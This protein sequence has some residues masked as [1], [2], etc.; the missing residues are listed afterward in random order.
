MN[1]RFR[2]FCFWSLH[3]LWSVSVRRSYLSTCDPLRSHEGQKAPEYDDWWCPWAITS[4]SPK[5]L[6]RCVPLYVV[7]SII[8]LIPTEVA[9]NDIAPIA[10]LALYGTQSKT[11]GWCS[12]F[13]NVWFFFYLLISSAVVT[14]N[15]IILCPLVFLSIPVT[16]LCVSP[17]GLFQIIRMWYCQ[18]KV[19]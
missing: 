1:S 12:F 7:L 8:I 5:F 17:T 9:R 10:R 18:S 13:S 16:Y 19:Q 11:E 3:Y 15:V 4:F 2:F 14:L 6:I